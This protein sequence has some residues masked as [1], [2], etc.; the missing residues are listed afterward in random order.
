[1]PKWRNIIAPEGINVMATMLK[2][3]MDNNT[4]NFHRKLSILESKQKIGS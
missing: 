2:N 1:M 4:N 3:P